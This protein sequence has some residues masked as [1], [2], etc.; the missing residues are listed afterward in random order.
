MNLADAL[1]TRSYPDRQIIVNQGDPADG[2][3]FVED[4][5]ILI[6]MVG[7][8]GIERNVRRFMPLW[9]RLIPSWYCAGGS[10]SG[11][12]KT[13]ST[14]IYNKLNGSNLSQSTIYCD[15]FR[16]RLLP[17]KRVATLAS[18]HSSL[19]NQELPPPR[20]MDR[21]ALHV[22][23]KPTILQLFKCLQ[24]EFTRK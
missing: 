6:V 21:S 20:L 22:R 18:W 12:A 24:G 13:Y 3:Y 23:F 9:C 16:Y 10:S 7:N 19:T 1:V 17:L 5:E 15:N 4:G 2:M 14:M 8:D 11:S